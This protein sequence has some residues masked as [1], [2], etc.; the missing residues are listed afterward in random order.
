MV[1]AAAMPPRNRNTPI[2]T[3]ECADTAA[4]AAAAVNAKPAVRTI[5]S[6]TRSSR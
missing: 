4:M 2:A 3:I 1:L 6:P 5:R